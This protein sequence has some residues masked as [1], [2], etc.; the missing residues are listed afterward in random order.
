MAEVAEEFKRWPL[1]PE[2]ISAVKF[3]PGWKGCS[4][5]HLK[6]INLAKTRNYPWVLIIEDDCII[7]K[8][9]VEQFNLLLPYLWENRA[10]WDIF[11]GGSTFLKEGSR[12]SSSPPIYKVKSFPA[13]FCLI[14][15]STF[16]KILSTHPEDPKDP[17]DVFYADNLRLWTTTPFFAKQRPGKSDISNNTEDYNSLFDEAEKTLINLPL[18][19]T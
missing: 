7:T 2:R 1:K 15:N 4:F 16:D 14:H 10:H 5:S 18:I 9:A 13:H 12:I 3:S 11:L 17:I 6:A 19:N 8:S